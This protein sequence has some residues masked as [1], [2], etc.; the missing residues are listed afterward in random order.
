MP[1]RRKGNWRP[2]GPVGMGNGAAAEAGGGGRR[3]RAPNAAVHRGDSPPGPAPEVTETC[4]F[5]RGPRAHG[6]PWAPLL[7]VRSGS[8]S[9][10]RPAERR[11]A[12]CPH[13]GTSPGP[14]KGRGAEATRAGPGTPPEAARRDSAGAKR[15]ERAS[16]Q[17]HWLSGAG[18]RAAG[19][20]LPPG[21][22][23]FSFFSFFE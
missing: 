22:G 9:V 8:P 1:A 20:R 19:P 6:F 17:G 16:P 23:L 14:R 10:H 18:A 11:E 4:V 5:P 21:T 13:D 12:A 7:R 15:P 3:L 2:A